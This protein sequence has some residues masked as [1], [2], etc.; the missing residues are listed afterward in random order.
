[1][2]P[3]IVRSQLRTESRQPELIDGMNIQLIGDESKEVQRIK[4][5]LLE[6]ENAGQSHSQGSDKPDQDRKPSRSLQTK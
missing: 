6:G 1:M 4:P 5:Q 3:I 2:H